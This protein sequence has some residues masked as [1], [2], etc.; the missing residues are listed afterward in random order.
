MKDLIKTVALEVWASQEI[1]SLK[2]QLAAQEAVNVKLRNIF[3]DLILTNISEQPEWDQYKNN[4][5]MWLAYLGRV[6]GT[7]LVIPSDT[8]ALN[9]LITK[10]GEVMRKRCADYCANLLLYGENDEHEWADRIHAL[11]S[12]TLEDL[13]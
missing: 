6:C 9:E 12:V 13:K 7:A 2:Q 11:P 1:E 10:A 8:T 5:D 3:S 4:G